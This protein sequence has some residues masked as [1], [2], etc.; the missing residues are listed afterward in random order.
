MKLYYSPGAC[1]MASRIVLEEAGI[2]YE[3][4]RVFFKDKRTADGKEV[5]FGSALR[6]T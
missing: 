2:A 6:D 4:V 5:G 1:S 3:A